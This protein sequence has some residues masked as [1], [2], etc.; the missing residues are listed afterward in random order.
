MLSGLDV[1]RT[2]HIPCHVAIIPDG[3]RRWARRKGLTTNDGHKKGVDILRGIARHAA[4][5]GVRYLSLWGL[6]LDNLRQRSIR[7]VAGLLSIFRSEFRALVDDPG[8]HE[9]RIRVNV[10]GKWRQRF[11]LPVRRAIEGAIAATRH[12]DDHV[13]TILLAYNGTDDM[14]A[15]IRGVARDILDRPRLHVT[16]ALLKR[17]LLTR[18][19]PHV[20]LLIRTAGEPH[21]SAGF[22]MWDVSDAQL[23][24]TDLYWPD[25]SPGEF[26]RALAE[27]ARRGRRLG[28]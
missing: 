5:R 26:D 10:L 3:N 19:L 27:Y 16:S 22:M 11:P 12:Y 1:G 6:S 15:A 23:Y 28:H 4:D 24:F 14:L 13:L 2:T 18:D 9:R 8:I 7:E 20:D 21:L 25:F 17:H